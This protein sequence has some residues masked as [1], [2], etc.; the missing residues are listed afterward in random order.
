MFVLA[1][2][3]RISGIIR[4][5]KCSLQPSTRDGAHAMHRFAMSSMETKEAQE[6]SKN[7][8]KV[9]SRT[10]A[11]CIQAGPYRIEGISIA[12]DETCLWIPSL[13]LAIDIGRCPRPAINMRYVALTHGHCDHIH[14]L[15]LH[16]A[17]RA[18]QKLPQ[19]TYFVPP[20]ILP[21]VRAF[22]DAVSALEQATIV[23]DIVPMSPHAAPVDLKPGWCLA[24]FPTNHTV[25]SQGYV[26]YHKR[27]KLR[28]EF[29]HLSKPELKTLKLH[30]RVSITS[31]VLTPELVFTGDTNIDTLKQSK[32]CQ[33]ARVLVTEI[34]FL[35]S[36]SREGSPSVQDAYQYGHIHYDQIVQNQHLFKHNEI[37]VFTH[38]SA[39]YSPETIRDALAEL[40]QSL[41][42]KVRALGVPPLI[43]DEDRRS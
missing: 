3:L 30:Q 35:P 40:P 29:K 2:P 20:D 5:T 18:L 14:G 27:Q 6:S 11:D 26:V 32:I 33:E 38:F 37:V 28:Q 4:H 39:R 36:R 15:P 42:T 21:Q 22:V 24:S 12:A 19:A 43:S 17:T 7:R 23:A 1:R 8:S 13:S 31:E 25:P 41:R 34:T 9:P 10:I 16:A